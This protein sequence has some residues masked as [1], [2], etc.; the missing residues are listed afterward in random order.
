MPGH[1]WNGGKPR[2]IV[3]VRQNILH[4]EAAR[5]ESKLCD[6][7][8][9]GYTL[10]PARCEVSHI[11]YNQS[12]FGGFLTG[13]FA[14]CLFFGDEYMYIEIFRTEKSRKDPCR[15]FRRFQSVRQT[16]RSMYRI[17]AEE[18]QIRKIEK[19]CR[20]RHYE[21]R[22]IYPENLGRSDNYR[23]KFL[24]ANPRPFGGY[25]CRYCHRRLSE[26]EMTV[27]HIYPVYLAK[28]GKNLWM[29]IAGIEDVNDVRNLA[30]ACRRCN[31]KKGSKAGIWLI[32]GILGRYQ[33]YWLLRWCIK[34]AVFG[35]ILYGGWRMYR[36]FGS[37]PVR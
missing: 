26:K 6:P 14:I 33:I 34:A 32:R 25:R 4:M 22:R 19:I 18:G 2:Q 12:R 29:R 7:R 9:A 28:T 5:A 35:L 15:A 3:S 11:G 8:R 1:S 30:P 36:C 17:Q 20:R 16:G 13:I 21:I 24:N 27:D 31:L 23:R 37:F 10:V